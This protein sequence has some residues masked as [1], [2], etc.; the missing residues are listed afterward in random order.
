MPVCL[1]LSEVVRADFKEEI[2]L[3]LVTVDVGWFVRVVNNSLRR[4]GG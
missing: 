3:G 4:W 1:V 2:V